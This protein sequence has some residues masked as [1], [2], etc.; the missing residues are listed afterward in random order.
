MLP[1]QREAPRPDKR[2][3]RRSFDRAVGDYDAVADVQRQVADELIERLA[4]IR[5]EPEVILDAGCGTGYCAARLQKQYR[6]AR[7]IGLD[8]APGMVQLA[9][10]RRPWFSRQQFAVGD[11]E[12]LPLARES[13]DLVV[14]SLALQWCDP[15]TVFAEVRRVLRPGGLFLFATFGPD[16]LHEIRAAWAAVDDRVHVHDFIDMHHL[17]DS[18]A[19]L[20]FELPVLD[21]D[22][23]RLRYAAPRDALEAIRRIGAGNIAPERARGLTG[24]R[25]YRRFV[26]A[27]EAM[28]DRDGRLPLSY[29]VVHGHAWVPVMARAFPAE[30]G[31]LGGEQSVRVPGPIPPRR[32]RR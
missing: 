28:R 29:E 2:L 10:R 7:V 14:S 1:E 15:F 23:L 5:I 31:A 26:E 4:V 27:Y 18:L 16:T 17:G 12:A 21:V 8:L 22:R 30:P 24:P 20:G 13:V 3:V 11:M 32:R 9:R 6:G 19:G 25:R